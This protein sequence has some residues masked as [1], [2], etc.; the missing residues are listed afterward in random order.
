MIHVYAWRW[1]GYQQEV[2]IGFTTQG[3]ARWQSMPV[4][5]DYPRSALPDLGEREVLNVIELPSP[6]VRQVEGLIHTIFRDRRTDREWFAVTEE[7]VADVF[8]TIKALLYRYSDSPLGPDESV[9][10]HPG[11]FDIDIG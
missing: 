4:P 9:G 2:K 10:D 7:E 11:Y 6:V 1:D 5:T 3:D 8:G